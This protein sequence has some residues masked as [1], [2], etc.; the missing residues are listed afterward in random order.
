MAA[1]CVH[2]NGLILAASVGTSPIRTHTTFIDVLAAFSEE[3]KLED[4]FLSGHLT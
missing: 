4:Y 2:T 3:T 1:D